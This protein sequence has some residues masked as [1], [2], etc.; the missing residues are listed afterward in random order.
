MHDNKELNKIDKF[1]CLKSLLKGLAQIAI[2][3]LIIFN[4]NYSVGL[5]ILEDCYERKRKK[6]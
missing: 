2:Q 5:K 3:R 6:C 1:K 4:E